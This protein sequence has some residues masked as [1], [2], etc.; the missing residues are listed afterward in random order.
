MSA[1]AH[2]SPPYGEFQA[3]FQKGLQ[4]FISEILRS[5]YSYVPKPSAK[6]L[7]V[8]FITLV[9]EHR[10]HVRRNIGVSGDIKVR[11]ERHCL[12]EDLMFSQD[13][14]DEY[15]LTQRDVRI[16]LD[17]RLVVQENAVQNHE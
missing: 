1:N 4:L 12:L 11:S 7:C 17:G 8:R 6:H 13:T 14:A 16:D 10:A 3:R 9:S 2:V 15:H 5:V